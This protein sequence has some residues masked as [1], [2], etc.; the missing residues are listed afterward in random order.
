[1]LVF[2][3]VLKKTRAHTHAYSPPYLP[4]N[5]TSRTF[6]RG[7]I[8]R[9]K[10]KGNGPVERICKRADDD[11]GGERDRHH[12]YATEKVG[13]SKTQQPIRPVKLTPPSRQA[14][15]DRYAPQQVIVA[16][17]TMASRRHNTYPR[18]T[19]H[20]LQ[21]EEALDFATHTNSIAL[22]TL[23]RRRGKRHSLCPCSGKSAR[24]SPAKA[25]TVY[26]AD[27]KTLGAAVRNT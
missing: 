17:A 27:R 5:S 1:M 9:P 7:K 20:P 16:E 15:T 3:T 22:D 8:R 23:A 6:L 24:P 11:A 25:P 26:N 18:T 13:L 10:R 12:A 19:L 21:S 2:K 14:G 4:P